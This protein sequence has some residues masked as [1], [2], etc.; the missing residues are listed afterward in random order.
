MLHCCLSTARFVDLDVV[1]NGL[2]P[3]PPR[4]LFYFLLERQTTI[5][6]TDSSADEHTD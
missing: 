5:G 6:G 4:L 1:L 3:P 2:I